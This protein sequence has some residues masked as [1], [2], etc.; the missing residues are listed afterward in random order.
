MS[1]P[2]HVQHWQQLIDRQSQSGLTVLQFCLANDVATHQFYFWR[3]KLTKP[4][5]HTDPRAASG[6]VPI[7][8]VSDSLSSGLSI[9]FASG[10]T[11][12]APAANLRDAIEQILAT[13]HALRGT[14]AC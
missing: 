3:R 11:I 5:A 13:E 1:S 7:R 2:E 6:L 9:R 14:A 10:A 4:K 12:D 8:I